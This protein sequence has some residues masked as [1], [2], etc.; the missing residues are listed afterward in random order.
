MMIDKA[1]LEA[2]QEHW[3]R[4]FG[5]PAPTATER[6][7]TQEER[8]AA[9][10]ARHNPEQRSAPISET[11]MRIRR[12]LDVPGSEFA[13]GAERYAADGTRWRRTA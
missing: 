7:P 8:I 4:V 1:E 2:S 13:V 6:Q 5:K 12:M 9:W 11:V 10:A 3:R